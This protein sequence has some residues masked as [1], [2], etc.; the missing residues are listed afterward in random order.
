MIVNRLR[1]NAVAFALAAPASFLSPQ[2]ARADAIQNPPRVEVQITTVEISKA[3]LDAS[4]RSVSNAAGNSAAFVTEL[5]KNGAKVT[6]AP[7]ITTTSGIQAYINVNVRV[8]VPGKVTDAQSRFET[9][10]EVTDVTPTVNPDGSITVSAK[11]KLTKIQ[12]AT[13]TSHTTVTESDAT[14]TLK[15][16][17]TIT[18]FQTGQSASRST[19]PGS[20]K[21]VVTLT[22]L[23][24]STLLP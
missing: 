6:A 12:S 23:K 22:F 15:N 17:A 8:P 16:G 4:L 3:G 10:S 2:I 20:A 19:H 13:H 18:L 9:L 14:Q 24:A 11:L 5:R 7:T 1:A 21:S